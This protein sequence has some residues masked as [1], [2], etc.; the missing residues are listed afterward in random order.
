[1][2][3]D[4]TRYGNGKTI[5]EGVAA[6]RKASDDIE[7]ILTDLEATYGFEGLYVETESVLTGIGR[8]VLHRVTVK[9]ELRGTAGD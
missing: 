4:P 3:E 5:E 1:M 9:A 8:A 2:S 6:L 7:R